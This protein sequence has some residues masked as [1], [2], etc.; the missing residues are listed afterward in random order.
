MHTLDNTDSE[1]AYP[2]DR[3]EQ[4]P[5]NSFAHAYNLTLQIA[6]VTAEKLPARCRP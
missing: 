4:P 5:R 2:L 6:V 3:E 1:H